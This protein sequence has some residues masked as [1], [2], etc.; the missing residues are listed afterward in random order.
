MPQ[1]AWAGG[2]PFQVQ[3][4]LTLAD[5]G[6]NVIETDDETVVICDLVPSLAA[7]K[8]IVINTEGEPAVTVADVSFITAVTDKAKVGT[9]GPGH[10][11]TAEVTF[12]QE[13]T[14]TSET[15]LVLSLTNTSTMV[16]T[17]DGSDNSVA[18]ATFDGS[19]YSTIV[20]I[21][22][23]TILLSTAQYNALDTGDPVTY[24]IGGGTA[25]D[26]L[27]DNAVYFAVKKTSP[28]IQVRQDWGFC[29]PPLRN[30]N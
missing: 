13:V 24:G 28:K 18:V 12:T 15:R 25:V 9:F 6:G 27:T 3:P 5:A 16:E 14:S 7:A 21:S 26:G 2:Q 30:I 19:D 10:V 20:D 22:A 17:F 1:N 8:K 29:L 23:D 11:V 4:Y